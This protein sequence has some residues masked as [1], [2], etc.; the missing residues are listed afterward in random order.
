MSRVG[1]RGQERAETGCWWQTPE[2]RVLAT[3]GTVLLPL[4]L[5]QGPDDSERLFLHNNLTCGH[6]SA[7]D[8]LISDCYYRVPIA[9]LRASALKLILIFQCPAEVLLSPEPAGISLCHIC[10]SYTVSTLTRLSLGYSVIYF[11]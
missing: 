3:V 11:Y 9:A 2:P 6:I 4:N 5:L 10:T 8:P 7:S 1:R